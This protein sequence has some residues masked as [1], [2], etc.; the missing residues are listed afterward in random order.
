MFKKLVIITVYIL[1]TG[2]LFATPPGKV[3]KGKH[4][5]SLRVPI[6]GIG[7]GNV[8]MGGRGNIAHLEIFNRPDRVRRLEKTFFALWTQQKGKKATAKLLERELFP[9]YQ[10]STHKYAAGLPR[11]TETEFVNNFPIQQ[12]KFKDADIP[13]NMEMEAFSP[14]IPQDVTNSSYPIVAFYWD[15]ENPTQ[16][17]VTASLVL[18]ME[19]PIMATA[20]S[21]LHYKKEA[22]QGVRFSAPKAENINHQG[23]LIMGTTSDAVSIQTHWFPGQW[24]DETHIFWDDFSADG[25][26]E[27][28]MEDWH[29]SYQPT[30]YNES[31]KRMASVLVQFKLQ[32]G[33]RIRIPFYLAWH[34]PK[35]TLQI[36]EVLGVEAAHNK[37]FE[38][39]YSNH[40]KND[41]DA[42]EQF[43]QKEKN[44]HHRSNQFAIALNNSSYPESV[45]ENLK[46][47]AATIRTNLIQV[48]SKGNVHGFE[49]VVSSGWCCP[50][51]C[52]HVWNY[53][54]TLAALF[55]SLERK[56]R[57]IEFLHNTFDNGFQAHRSVIPIGDYWF[58]GPAAA[59]GQM[60]TII[61]AYREWKLSGDQQ[62]LSKLWPK[63]KKCL[64][65]AWH[66]PGKVQDERFK[67]QEKQTPWDKNKTGLLSG[68]Q[69]NTYDINF[70]GP[71]SMTSS[72]Y[73]G[74]LKACSEMALAMGEID[75]SKEYAAIY[76]KGLEAFKN[77]L[78][79][80]NYFIQIIAAAP[81]ETKGTIYEPPTGTKEKIPKYQYGDGCLSD[82]LLGQY[83][84][85]ISGLDYIID[86]KMVD[87]AL[88]SIYKHNFINPLR[89]F[90]NVQRVYG[91]NE[92][93]G[94][95]LCTWP[96]DNRPALPFV[97]A[98]EIWTGVEFQVAASLIYADFVK[99]GLEIVDAVHQRHDGFKRNPFEQDESGVHYARA[100]A[101]WSLL[102]ALSGFEYDG[103]A[104]QL[105]FKPKINQD[106]FSTFWSTGSAWGHF[107]IKNE[108]ATL[109]V[110]EG[111][112]ELN[113]FEIKGERTAIKE[114][115][116]K[117]VAG[118]SLQIGLN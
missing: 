110:I 53:E 101:S 46:T 113:R 10:E 74:A 55:P 47:Q 39:A 89:Q 5:Q 29:T 91:L 45:L 65:F 58:D 70:Y 86:K 56:M 36:H 12:W 54:Q 112:L 57:E 106:H 108:N 82:Q 2:F 20:I 41:L 50:G 52:T 77:T 40:F 35:R 61:R 67:H 9:P 94:L 107:S 60:G 44:L 30:S 71:S 88:K 95:V 48:T 81:D 80:G 19:N 76:E 26:I 59:D 75:K 6:G 69:H 116:I 79:N 87:T 38:N 27:S 37:T 105:A 7:T 117:L 17:E 104:K 78:W 73:L 42:L 49:G 11:V 21:N 22:F 4:L 14:F 96:N 97:Y 84:A 18:N 64:E 100:M 62:W 85:F 102:L 98:D 93:A 34:F 66:G 43:L 109:K 32:P 23:S 51:T 115:A 28:K 72:I 83:L 16:E 13:L 118:E 68:L 33:E 111:T 25:Q 90:S 114:Q 24:R 99:E 3:Y 15:F 1:C 103:F 8:L 63:I 31:T 92:E